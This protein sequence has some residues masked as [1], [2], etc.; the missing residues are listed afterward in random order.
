MKLWKQMIYSGWNLNFK[1]FPYV[2]ELYLCVSCPEDFSCDC[3][4]T[5]FKVDI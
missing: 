1:G 3:F 5:H 2:D 4:P